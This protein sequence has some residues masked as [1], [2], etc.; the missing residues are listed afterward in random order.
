MISDK[1]WLAF[2]SFI[3]SRVGEHTFNADTEFAVF[4]K[5]RFYTR[6]SNGIVI[7]QIESHTVRDHIAR[8]NRDFGV[9]HTGTNTHRAL[10]NILQQ[11]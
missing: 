2:Y 10:V 8:G 1:R 11:C 3:L 9:L 7:K 6:V 5:S 4:V